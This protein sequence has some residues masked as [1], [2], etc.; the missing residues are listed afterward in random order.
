MKIISF[1]GFNN[2]HETTYISYCGQK[3]CK[4]PFFQEALVEF[5]K[6]EIIYV[7]LT[8]TVET[9]I[10]K[11]AEQTNWSALQKRLGA[12]VRLQ[13]ISDIPERNSPED[14]WT[15]FDKVT[16]V[17]DK[18]DEVIFDITHSFRSV[19]VV[20]LIAASYLRV[21]RGVK[22]KGLLYGAFEAQNKE[23]KET[24]TFDLL[25]IVSLLNWTTATDQFIKTGNGEEL[26]SLLHSS[27]DEAED[28]AR[29][30]HGISQGLDLL[31][32]MDVMR[33]SANLPHFIE[34][35]T[36][37]ISEFIPPFNMLLNRVKDDYSVFGLI[38]PEDYVNNAK[39]ALLKELEMI[40]WYVSKGKIIQALSLARE[41][42][43]SLL[44]C[45]FNLDPQIERPN[46]YQ[47]ELL[48]NG[49]RTP[50][51]SEESPYLEEWQKIPKQKRNK[52]T[53][54]WAGEFNLAK[55]RNDVLHAG[56]RKNPKS[57]EEI[58]G[59]TWQI[60]DKL[61][62]IAKDWGIVDPS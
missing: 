45:Y 40:E 48:L 12:D 43:P 41:W 53:N 44:C 31:R 20:A 30:I 21:V 34:K 47:M 35:T 42:L 61:R 26:A 22:I 36:P 18:G 7:M 38:Q 49:G 15:I 9:Q 24:P 14:I 17:L 29:S 39:S 25:P 27:H 62:E 5:Y 10:P 1:L 16:A 57:A 4:T 46:R 8:K 59:Q 32:P 3:A 52:L 50:D 28:L 37:V 60:I 19:P 56:F 55:L 23:T 6:P 58:L 33:E 13:A 2:Y 51:K 11:G 54:L